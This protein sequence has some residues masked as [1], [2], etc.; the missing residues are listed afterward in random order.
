MDQYMTEANYLLLAVTAFNI[1]AT[2]YAIQRE[3]K[4]RRAVRRALATLDMVRSWREDE[5]GKV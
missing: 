5:E 3:V 2:A 1:S 4:R